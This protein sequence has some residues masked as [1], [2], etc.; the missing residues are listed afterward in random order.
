M[1][2]ELPR[3]LRPS[4]DQAQRLLRPDVPLPAVEDGNNPASR[5]NLGVR[6]WA[7]Q[8]IS[9]E[10]AAGG[11]GFHSTKLAA[12]DQA[13]PRVGCVGCTPITARIS[14]Q[15]KLKKVP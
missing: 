3:K 12:W 13:E 11:V 2:S 1:P 5:H 7:A 14:E 6:T 9:S 4:L 10:R 15:C 8:R